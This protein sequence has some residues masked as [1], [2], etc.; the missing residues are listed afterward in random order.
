[1]ATPVRRI[2]AAGTGARWPSRVGFGVIVMAGALAAR[3]PSLGRGLFD[4]DEAAIATMGMV[5]S[6]GGVLYRDVI[7]R[8]PPI[9]P[10]L[11]A[12]TFWVTGSRHLEPLHIVAAL[13]LGGAALVV[14]YEV[15]QRAGRRAAWWAAG[16]LLAGAVALRPADAQAANYSHLALLP[17]CGA[18][19]AARRGSRSSVL[20]AGVLLGLAT[21]TRQTWLIGLVPAAVAVWTRGRR[22][23]R[24][25]RVAVLVVSTVATIAAVAI[26]VPFGPFV[27]WTFSGNGSLV[28]NLGQVQRPIGR[29]LDALELFVVGHIGLCVLVLLRRWRRADLDLW[30]WVLTGL[31]AVVA[32]FRYFGHYWLQVLPALCLLA[33][34]AIASCTAWTRVAL[35]TLVVVPTFFYWQQAWAPIHGSSNI[36]QRAFPLVAEVRRRTTG[37]DLVTVWGSF[38]EIYWLSGRAPGGALVITD[39]IVGRTAGRPDGPQRLRDAT[40]GALHDF[41]ASV[42]AHPPKLFLDTS[43]GAVRKYQHYP[44]TLIPSVRAFVDQHYRPVAVVRGVTVYEL[45]SARSR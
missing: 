6:R 44:L 33:A 30:L 12:L 23:D 9:A 41:L 10:L 24:V 15:R 45:A 27:H 43:T 29:G 8:K 34:P 21:L 3:A 18:I 13:E 31:I 5:V 36:D 25:G 28:F 37:G 4:P 26:V 42:R 14:A 1:M 19:V 39:F 38:P 16:L 40:P 11:Y 7:D 35:A 20:A 2:A 17:A 22:S 32:G